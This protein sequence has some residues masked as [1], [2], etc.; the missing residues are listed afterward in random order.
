MLSLVTLPL[1]IV[2]L[3]TL[4]GFGARPIRLDYLVY[5][6]AFVPWLYRAAGAAR[7]RSARPRWR[8]GRGRAARLG[9]RGRRSR[10][11]LGRRAAP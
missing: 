8:R 6:W 10:R 1:T 11:V 4:F 7:L 2:Q 5:L 9:R 3:Q